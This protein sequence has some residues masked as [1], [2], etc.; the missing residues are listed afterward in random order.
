MWDAINYSVEFTNSHSQEIAFIGHSKGGAEALAAA[1]ATGKNA[2][3]FNPAKPNLKDYNLSEGNYD[4]NAISYVVRG[5][6]LNNLF[7][8]PGIVRV[9]YLKQKYK[10]PWYF[11]GNARNIANLVNPILNHFM[12]AVLSG[13]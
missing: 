10:T 11:V 6:I 9:E 4:G 5:E 3:A 13:I 2:I 8:E 7:G 12:E 1:V